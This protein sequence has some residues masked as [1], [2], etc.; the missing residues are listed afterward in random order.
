MTKAIVIDPNEVR[1]R[2]ALQAPDVLMNVYQSDPVAEAAKYGA[3]GLV[4][5]YRDMIYIR[6]FETMLDRIKKE[7]VYQGIEYNHKGPAHLSI[8]QESAAVGQAVHLGPEDFIFGSHRSH[9]EIIAKSLSAIAKISEADL[10][11]VMEGYLG[12][13]TLR[14]VERLQSTRCARPGD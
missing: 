13:A 10:T 2:G 9:G 12:G 11:S 14:V 5:I 3:D 8:G 6:E 1:R 7:G 4:R